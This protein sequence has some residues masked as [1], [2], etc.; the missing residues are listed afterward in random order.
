MMTT[1]LRNSFLIFAFTCFAASFTL[2]QSD[3]QTIADKMESGDA[4][5]LAGMV[6]GKVSLTVGDETGTYNAEDFKAKLVSFFAS[7]K[8][9]DYEMMRYHATEDG[10]QLI[11]GKLK[12]GSKDY[13]V[14]TYVKK[15]DGK[16]MIRQIRIYEE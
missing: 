4:V 1:L 14:Y 2:A 7:N 5:A 13:M 8:P 3:L 15:N 10:M 9:S 12:A 11:V 6:N 16:R